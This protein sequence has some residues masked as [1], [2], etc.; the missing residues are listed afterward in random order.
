MLHG[1]NSDQSLQNGFKTSPFEPQ[2][3]TFIADPKK[4]EM[5][6]LTVDSS[7][8]FANSLE[9]ISGTNDDLC[10]WLA[11]NKSKLVQNKLKREQNEA[12]FIGYRLAETGY[13]KCTQPKLTQYAKD[14]LEKG[15]LQKFKNMYGDYYVQ[16]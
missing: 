8:S 16:G 3:P 6:W 15:E 12:I 7:D 1:F 2:V 11:E 4:S 13:F 5:Y 9:L 14:L 10:G